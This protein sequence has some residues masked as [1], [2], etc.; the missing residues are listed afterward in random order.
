VTWYSILLLGLIAAP[1]RLV[2][3]MEW[4]LSNKLLEWQVDCGRWATLEAGCQ[5]CWWWLNATVM[6]SFLIN[7]TDN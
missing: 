2:P 3:V 1:L 7:R 6:E 4:G 5:W